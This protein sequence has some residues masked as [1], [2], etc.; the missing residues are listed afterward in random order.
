MSEKVE[1]IITGDNKASP[2]IN[3]VAA[4]LTGLNGS[5]SLVT[6]AMMKLAPYLGGAALAA[7]AA[8]LISMAAEEEAQLKQLESTVNIIGGSYENS[9]GSIN[10]FIASMQATTAYGD[11]EMR[12]VLQEITLLTGDLNKGFEGA[13]IA[14]DMAASGLFN[15]NSASRY[16]AMAMEGNTMMLGRYIP[17]L[18][19]A[20]MAQKGFTTETQKADY[21]MK[22]LNEKFG[23]MAEKNVET[24]A[25]QIKQFQNYLG[26]FGE[27]IGTLILPALTL[28]M[29]GLTNLTKELTIQ[30]TIL[31]EYKVS[32]SDLADTQNAGKG[33]QD[34]IN[35]T[36]KSTNTSLQT[37]DKS[38]KDYISTNQDLLNNLTFTTTGVDASGVAFTKASEGVKKTT[39]EIKGVQAKTE[40][41]NIA[42]MQHN[43]TIDAWNKGL[44]KA[45]RNFINLQSLQER[46]NA[47]HPRDKLQK[48][49]LETEY[50]DFNQTGQTAG[51]DFSISFKDATQAGLQASFS[52][53][54]Q[55]IFNQM[56]GNFGRSFAGAFL[57]AFISALMAQLAAELALALFSGGMAVLPVPTLSMGR[58]GI[59]SVRS[60]AGSIEAVRSGLNDLSRQRRDYL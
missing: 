33:V 31:D 50:P 42:L 60:G 16:V 25:G 48:W 34:A 2:A 9:K 1:V 52:T 59:T 20:A 23:G 40:E 13:R 51:E 19:D 11:G 36:V 54:L 17:E 35:V 26:D 43:I 41:Y 37:I 15:L 28:F 29:G 58:S 44:E 49:E 39:Q 56:G 22:I 10:S 3:Q 53:A 21:A 47:A 57:Q 38:T 45:Y 12:P 30:K 27:S 5:T 6:A 24:Y 46:I 4:S 8:K 55:P 32:M 14:A 7:G 18:K